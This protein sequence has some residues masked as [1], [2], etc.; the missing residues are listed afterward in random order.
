M[1]FTKILAALM[2]VATSLLAT[3]CFDDNDNPK[4]NTW[5]A[6]LLPKTNIAAV[7]D[8]N[9]GNWTAYEGA[10]VNLA[11]NFDEQYTQL[12]VSG[13]KLAAD[14]MLTFSLPKLTYAVASDNSWVLDYP[15]PYSVTGTNGLTYKI[16]NVYVK[17]RTPAQAPAII[18][19][20]FMVDEKYM[21]RCIPIFNYFG[22]TTTITYPEGED[23]KLPQGS[24]S[25]KAT[26]Y[27]IALDYK[28]MTAE[29][30]IYQP[31][32]TSNMPQISDLSFS[33]VPFKLTDAGISF[34]RENFDPNKVTFNQSTGD[35][36]RV[37][38]PQYKV[39]KFEGT[40]SVASNLYFNYDCTMG[41]AAFNGQ[42]LT[43]VPDKNS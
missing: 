5:S 11:F 13:L 16:S 2:V 29:M 35:V 27:N 1:K 32:F 23:S 26:Y 20:N 6:S 37:P 18:Q 14:Q 28:T 24:F 40:M 19:V 33:G 10:T 25:T 42:P 31:R 34:E 4:A 9:T 39:S 15:G 41:H 22:G 21:V 7:K 38:A 30:Y 12:T 8:V 43:A 3:S 36:T 17:L